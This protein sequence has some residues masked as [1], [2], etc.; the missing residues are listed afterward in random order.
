M[1]TVFFS[2]VQ[3]I[4]FFRVNSYKARTMV[5][6]V[7]EFETP[8]TLRKLYAQTHMAHK[9]KFACSYSK[10]VQV[11]PTVLASPG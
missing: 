2:P 1:R 5:Y 6:K 4:V 3:L 10:D 7:F 9:S 8:L 11:C